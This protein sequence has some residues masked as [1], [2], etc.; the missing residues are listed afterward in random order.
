MKKISRRKFIGTSAFGLL[1]AAYLPS[2]KSATTKSTPFGWPLSFQS[3]GVREMLGED[4]S[5]TMKKLHDIGFAGIEMCSPKGYENA[6]F[7]PLM[8]YSASE[9]KKTLEDLNNQIKELSK[10]RT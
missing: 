5:G 8:K 10:D 4:F 3:Y 9:L 6:G 2:C 1:A 7:A